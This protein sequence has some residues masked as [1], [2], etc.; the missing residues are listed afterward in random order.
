MQEIKELIDESKN[1]VFF[2][3]AGV[4]T[5]SGIPDFRGPEGIYARKLNKDPEY[6]LS[7]QFFAEYPNDFYEFYRSEMLCT[8]AKPNPAHIFLAQMENAGRLNAVIT[9]NIDGLHQKAGSQNVLE[10]HG[11]IY[12]N[13]CVNCNKKYNIS[14]I[15]ESVG[16]P[17]CSC[18]GIVRPNVVL[19][20]ES[21]DQSTMA[22]A[23]TQI[24]FADLIIV[25]GTS[26][27]VYPAAQLLNYRSPNSKLVLIN[28]STT[29]QDNYADIVIREP[30]A[31]AFS[32]LSKLLS[33][34]ILDIN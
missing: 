5:Q 10:L 13:Y 1:I 32:H 33:L 24:Q 34:D 12:R 14:K 20:G 6:L 31:E 26:L 28:K 19:Y 17:K 23:I 22:D 8:W 25:G 29:S 2:G 3:G 4:S 15:T 27:A 18:G 9:Q 11:S 30:I 16:I 21:L 7:H